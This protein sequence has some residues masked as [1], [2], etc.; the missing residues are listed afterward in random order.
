MSRR[1]AL[2][3]GVLAAGALAL[4]PTGAL[5]AGKS[6]SVNATPNPDVT[7]DPV[8][9]YGQL[10]A[11]DHG[12]RPV[13]LWHRVAGRHRFTPVSRT[14]TSATGFYSFQK[15]EGIVRTN[16]RW[17]V[18]SSRVR[19]AT[20]QEKVFAEVRLDT[21]PDSVAAHRRLR[22]TGKVT[23]GRVHRRE[24]VL[25]QSAVGANGDRWRTIDRGRIRRAGTFVIG[26]AFK[27]PGSRTVRVVLPRDRFNLRST[28]SPVSFDVQGTQNPR[29]TLAASANPIAEGQAVRLSG[30]LA[31]RNAGDRAVTLYARDARQGF[32]AVASTTTD[33][34]GNYSF[35]QTPLY[36]TVYQAR[37]GAGHRRS[38][39]VAVGVHDV[40]SAHPSA[41]ATHVGGTVVVTGTVVPRKP[42]H[43]VYLQRLGD[44][45]AFHTIRVTR[46][47]G[48]SQ[49]A[50]AHTFTNSGTKTFRVLVPGGA[51]NLRG[52]S[53]A[54]QIVVAP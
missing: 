52:L 25:L 23:P 45:A 3:A 40:V 2:P 47:N 11:A 5:A 30:S 7:G 29:F 50:F 8:T 44:D 53:D 9:I 41:T 34:Q 15:A 24:H 42:G 1:F 36:N 13:T 17:F 18:R 51:W 43:I 4:A 48:A 14:R 38:T 27:Q 26:H 37:A 19:S 12:D 46:L 22:F 35:A 6:I 39:R 33:A 28:S 54:F 31:G 16:R 49:Y 20:V 21:P 10:T 32:R